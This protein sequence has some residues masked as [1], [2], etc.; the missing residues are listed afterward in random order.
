V[1]AVAVGLILGKPTGAPGD[2][3]SLFL[4]DIGFGLHDFSFAHHF[5]LDAME[6]FTP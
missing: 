3:A 6:G 4:D 5:L 2:L 1:G